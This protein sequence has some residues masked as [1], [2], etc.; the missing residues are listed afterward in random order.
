MSRTV[1]CIK[2]KKE[3]LGLTVPPMPGPKGMWVYENVCQEAWK[4]W[5]DH[6]TRLI[7]EKQLSMIDP[8]SRKYLHEQMDKFFKGDDYD[9]ADGYVPEAKQS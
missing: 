8:E 3:A 1:N 9:K 4:M 5:T 6:Q 7:N 2:L